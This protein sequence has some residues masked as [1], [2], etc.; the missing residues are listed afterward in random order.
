MR[1]YVGNLPWD[2]RT[3][4]VE[5][6]F[7]E[8]GEIRDISI[9]NCFAFVEYYNWRDADDAVCFVTARLNMC[10]YRLLLCFFVPTCLKHFLSLLLHALFAPTCNRTM[11]T[12]LLS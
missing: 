6:L 2:V 11:V 4:D 12:D 9:H 1:L 10:C 3:R 7:D 8:F 5:R